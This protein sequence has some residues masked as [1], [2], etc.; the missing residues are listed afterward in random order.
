[1]SRKTQ[2]MT[3]G[4]DRETLAS[5]ERQHEV[6]DTQVRSTDGIDYP[7]VKKQ[8]EEL[9][10]KRKEGI[11]TGELTALAK[12]DYAYFSTKFPQFLKSIVKDCEVDRLDEFRRVMDTLL[13]GLENVQKGTLTQSD[14]RKTIFEG[15]LATQYFRPN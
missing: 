3:I 2:S 10:A 4:N 8:A 14:L 1:M 15:A 7:K 5:L 12:R 11:P 13:S 6:M 9:I